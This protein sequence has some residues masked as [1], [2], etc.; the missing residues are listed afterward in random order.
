MAQESRSSDSLGLLPSTR[1]ARAGLALLL[2][3]V[4]ALT[5]WA[6]L[7]PDMVL[8]WESLMALCAGWR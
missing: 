7:Q 1:L 3:G 4:L 2:A 6:Y 8:A 5:V